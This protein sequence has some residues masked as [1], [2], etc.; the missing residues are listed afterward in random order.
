MR[1]FK[2]PVLALSSHTGSVLE[3]EVSLTV[4]KNMYYAVLEWNVLQVYVRSI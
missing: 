2:F 3:E 4:E 1:C